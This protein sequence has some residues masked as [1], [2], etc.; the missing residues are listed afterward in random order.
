M[1]GWPEKILLP[2][3]DIVSKML[4]FYKNRVRP[5]CG[6]LKAS[7][8][9]EDAE[10]DGAT[11]GDPN[12]YPEH[13]E[14][15]HSVQDFRV[16]LPRHDVNVEIQQRTFPTQSDR[17]LV[18]GSKMNAGQIKWGE[19]YGLT[20]RSVLL[21]ITYYDWLPGTRYHHWYVLTDRYSGHEYQNSPWYRPIEL[22]KVPREY[23]GTLLWYWCR[24]FLATTPE[25]FDWLAERG[26]EE[27]AEAVAVLKELS[28]DERA[29]LRAEA[30]EKWLWDQAAREHASRAEGRAE[31]RV[32]VAR[33]MLASKMPVSDIAKFTSLSEADVNRLKLE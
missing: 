21:P 1:P 11:L 17:W 30:R 28:A 6:L 5:V 20:A 33:S 25:E 12:L 14:D 29:R 22:L 31:G 16:N 8:G 15:K 32:E 4:F 10:L 7:F 23:D 13:E 27:M 2:R 18:Y 26:G 3:N 9:F 19:D 24:F